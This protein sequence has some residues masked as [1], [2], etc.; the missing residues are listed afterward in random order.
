M[1]QRYTLKN[2]TR[3][4]LVPQQE[5]GAVTLLSLFRVGSRFED[6]RTLGISH[7]LEHMMFKGTKKRPDTLEI[8]REL[9][10]VG[11]EYNAFTS[12]DHTGYYI[13]LNY[14]KADM[15]IDIMYDMLANSLVKPE[16]VERERKV[17]MEEIHMYED[18]PIM[19][20]EELYEEELYRG[21]SLG[22][23]IAGD[24][25]SLAHVGKKELVA[26][27]HEH[28][29]PHET[30]FVVA[31]RFTDGMVKMIEDT[32]GSAKKRDGRPRQY[33]PF[34]SAAVHNRGPRVHL[35]FKDTGQVQVALGFPAYK[36][37]D[38]R[39]PALSVLSTILGGTMSSRLF[40]AVRERRGLAYSVRS[41]INAYE[42]IG[43]LVIQSGLDKSRVFE[44]LKVI[45]A[46]LKRM[47]MRGVTV[48]ELDRA[49]EN[50][51]G[52]ITLALE[53]SSAVADFY[54]KQELHAGKVKTPEER[55]EKIFAVTR[56]E[57]RA[58]ARE[59]IE[60]KKLAAAVIGPFEDVKRFT[61]LLKF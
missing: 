20:V 10:G 27:R 58:A 28:Y 46:E 2:G 24:K 19:L 38:A 55:I 7:F 33:R 45:M 48:D 1:F 51:R 8:S 52:R 29:L 47:V 49:K 44:A 32:F 31:G 40:I 3:V 39:M 60:P 57:I 50:I 53:D 23:R 36:L 18:N 21:S 4:I 16:E 14:E 13:K 34:K 12:K 56:E 37:E 17:I 26:F 9:D 59:I 43:N 11:A 41:S 61:K 5:T 42:D 54:G 35:K 15:A 6:A 25:K 22:W 30:V